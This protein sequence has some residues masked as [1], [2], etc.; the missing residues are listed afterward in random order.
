VED[1]IRLNKRHGSLGGGGIAKID[2]EKTVQ[3]GF[4]IRLAPDAEE[5]G[6]RDVAKEREQ[7]PADVPAG[8]CDQDSAIV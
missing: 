8:T 7:M 4:D 3:A 6:I 1:E 2:A 5:L